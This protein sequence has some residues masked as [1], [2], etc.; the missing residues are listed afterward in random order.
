MQKVV[1][2]GGGFH[3]DD[4]FAVATLQ[5]YLGEENIEI[6]RTR[7]ESIINS[8]DWVIDVGAVYDP[9]KKRFDHH[10]NGA[11]VRDNGIPYAAF[12]LIWKHYG[13]EVSGSAEVAEILERKLVLPIDANDN[14][15]SLYQLNDKNIEPAVLQDVIALFKPEWGSDRD[16]DS[17]FLEACELARTIIK[18]AVSHAVAGLKEEQAAAVA[19]KNAPDKRVV[20]S[21]QYLSSRLFV[22]YPETLVVVCPEDSK[23]SKNWTAITVR[24]HP[25]GFE[26]RIQFPQAWAGLR[27]AGLA[28][29]SG[30][31]D[32]VFCHKTPFVFVAKSKEGALEAVSKILE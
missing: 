16:M 4:V 3:A 17:A 11:P 19:Y 2:H 15:V 18:R 26:S 22:Q 28:A 9:T 14:G 20:V 21:P 12:G 13:N 31:P 5:L 29:V 23:T 6:L 32:A 7:D 1:T 30:V 27:D 24:I 8:A 10:Q 25:T